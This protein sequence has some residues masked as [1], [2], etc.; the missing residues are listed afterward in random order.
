MKKYYVLRIYETIL[1]TVVF[2][3]NDA[4]NAQMYAVIMAKED[5]HN[6]AV[7]SAE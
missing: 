5:N 2:Q 4:Y 1:P 7:V 6:Y 3:T